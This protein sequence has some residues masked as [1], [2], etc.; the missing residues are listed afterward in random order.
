MKSSAHLFGIEQETE[1]I[2]AW[3]DA[4]A[5]IVIAVV[6]MAAH[7]QVAAFHTNISKR[8]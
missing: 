8:D 4:T 3:I 6:I 2:R 7:H 5:L 1:R